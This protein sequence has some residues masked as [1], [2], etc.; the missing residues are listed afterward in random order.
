VKENMSLAE[1][2]LPPAQ[3]E[4]FQFGEWNLKTVKSHI[5]KSEGPDR[6]RFESQLRLPQVPEMIFAD[7]I[8]QLRHQ[9]GFGIEFNALDA[10]KLVDPEN[11]LLK[12]A[13]AKAWKDAREDCEH[14]NEVV[15]PFDWTFSTD[16]KGT[17][18]GTNDTELKVSETTERIDLEKL[19]VREKIHFYA[20]I[21]LFEDELADNG[22]SML[23]VKIRI[24]PTSLFIL[25]R[26]HMRVD[27]VMVRINETRVYHESGRNYLLREYTS[28]EAKYS[29]LNIPLHI[30]TDPNEVA[31]HL[32]VKE[33]L[34]QKLQ[35][36]CAVSQGMSAEAAAER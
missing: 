7:N 29:E 10:L 11:D 26:F 17:L 19:K 20:D 1:R 32:P 6:E 4:Q 22:S 36:P 31:Q 18:L 27:G 15:K 35:F 9:K 21:L 8:L 5:L 12:V 16:Y 25:L 3:V 30:I 34:F 24:M 23:S 2:K 13:V 14:I 33:Q 28:K